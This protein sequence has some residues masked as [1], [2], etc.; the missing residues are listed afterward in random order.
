MSSVRTGPAR[1][2]EDLDRPQARVLEC[3][4]ALGEMLTRITDE[5]ER[6]RLGPWRAR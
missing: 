6:E 3:E 1:N 2:E 5:R 4:G